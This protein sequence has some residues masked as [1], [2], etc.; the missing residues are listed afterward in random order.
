MSSSKGKTLHH[1]QLSSGDIAALERFVVRACGEA[2]RYRQ[3]VDPKSLALANA[4]ETELPCRVPRFMLIVDTAEQDHVFIVQKLRSMG[5]W[6][7]AR[8]MHNPTDTRYAPNF[9]AGD[10]AVLEYTPSDEEDDDEQENTDEYCVPADYRVLVDTERKTIGDAIA[11]F[12]DQRRTRQRADHASSSARR[13]VILIEGNMDSLTAKQA[14]WIRII[15]SDIDHLVY[16]GPFHVRQINSKADLLPTLGNMVRYAAMGVMDAEAHISPMMA[17]SLSGKSQR[18]RDLS[19]PETV[20]S[21]MLQAVPGLSA[22][23][24]GAIISEHYPTFLD[25]ARAVVEASESEDARLQMAATLRDTEIKSQSSSSSRASTRL[26]SRGDKLVRFALNLPVTENLGPKK[27]P[28]GK[29]RALEPVCEEVSAD[30]DDDD[31]VEVPRAPR[32]RVI[33]DDS[34][35]DEYPTASSALWDSD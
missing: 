31:V 28:R 7:V 16:D 15:N 17:Y 10:F 20:W 4:K 34:D 32:K 19:D 33:I 6:A 21:G 2:A 14:K 30:D 18:G 23:A 8:S 11:S 13:H 25:F 26:A 27:K 5:Y 24:A 12:L 22:A 1:G 35:S 3:L 29:K 9:F